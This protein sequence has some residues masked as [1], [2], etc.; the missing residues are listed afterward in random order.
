MHTGPDANNIV[1]VNATYHM[2][3]N[4]SGRVRINL[5]NGEIARPW[6]TGDGTFTTTIDQTCLAS[7]AHPLTA[8]AFMCASLTPEA[9]P[10]D[11][12]YIATAND[13]ITVSGQTTVD[14]SYDQDQNLLTIN[15]TFPNAPPTSTHGVSIYVDGYGPVPVPITGT[16]FTQ[17][18]GTCTA[19]VT[20]SC[21]VTHTVRVTAQACNSPDPMYHAE[22]TLPVIASTPICLSDTTCCNSCPST[23]PECGVGGSSSCPTCG[24]ENI[25]VGPPTNVGSGDVSV[26]LPLF[27]IPQEPTPLRFD[28]TFHSGKLT[29]PSLVNYPM[30]IGWTHT[31]NSSIKTAVDT[32]LFYYTPTGN[33]VYFD[34]VTDTLWSAA[35]PAFIADVIIKDAATGTYTVK[36]PSGGNR[37]YSIATGK[38]LSASDR[39]G[40]TIS[41]TYDGSGNLTTIT[42]SVGRQITLEYVGGTI[43]RVVLPGG[44]A[45]T[46]SYTTLGTTTVLS[47]IKDPVNPTQIWRSFNY[48]AP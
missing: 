26:N 14:A 38:W 3:Y 16:C 23:G 33:R 18:S 20:L 11:P 29:F 47:S 9:D 19:P 2:P 17:I 25:C 37:V 30:G 13:S 40:N 48:V 15:T 8:K 46:F 7:G 6:V 44:A 45:W 31:F 4:K 10:T 27:T 34:R 24:H 39:W 21:G 12:V 32:R 28:L 36:F 35:R 5:D 42:D 22:T 41:G 43:S 1:T